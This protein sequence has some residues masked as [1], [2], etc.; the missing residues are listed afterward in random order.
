MH[1]TL[2]NRR[3]LTVILLLLCAAP[4][5]ARAQDFVCWPIVRGDTA[6]SL[7]RRLTGDADR[8]YSDIFQIRDPSRRMFV[9]KSQYRRLHTDWQACV[10]RGA[11]KIPVLAPPPAVAPVV[12]VAPSST[13]NASS[14]PIAVAA[15]LMLLTG[16]ALAVQAAPRPIPPA[17]RRAGDAFISEFAR[18][19][20]DPSS[21]TAP[22]ATRLRFVRR[23]QQLEISIA[24]G[25]GRRYPNLI[26]HKRNVE[27]DVVRVMRLLGSGFVVSDRL[28][29]AG[30]WVVVRIRPADLK[31]AG[32]P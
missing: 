29:A 30:K 16:M 25:Q 19:L 21:T 24:P 23:A 17:V 6:S 15:F 5:G 9:P 11:V 7:A 14:G 27:Y 12:P 20:I 22:I 28:R 1:A 31:Q 13:G 18:P 2:R 26:D 8:A 3:V 10:A 32:A 4:A